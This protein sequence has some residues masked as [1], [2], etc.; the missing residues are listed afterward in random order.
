MQYVYLSF[1]A[2]YS[3]PRSLS[4]SHTHALPGQQCGL[5]APCGILAKG[6]EMAARKVSMVAQREC[7]RVRGLWCGPLGGDI[8]KG[9]GRGGRIFFSP[10]T[11]LTIKVAINREQSCQS[12]PVG[13]AGQH[14]KAAGPER[15]TRMHANIQLNT[16]RSGITSCPL[17]ALPK[18]THQKGGWDGFGSVTTTPGPGV[19]EREKRPAGFFFSLFS[20]GQAGGGATRALLH[21]Q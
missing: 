13:V 18:P 5:R 17:P 16:E 14:I 8:A 10:P 4:P 21:Y 1:G 2:V 20:V 9:P 11:A 19:P 6:A 15:Q 3:T 7:V 12:L